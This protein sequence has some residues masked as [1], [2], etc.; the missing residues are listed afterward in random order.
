[1]TLG[2]TRPLAVAGAGRKATELCSH[3]LAL[4]C[5]YWHRE[6][7]TPWLACRSQRQEKSHLEQGCPAQ[8]SLKPPLD[9]QTQ[10]GFGQDERQQMLG[11][12]NSLVLRH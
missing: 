4:L 8:P 6:R 3:L 12:S 1:M 10:G 7:N 2:T 9:P 5:F 11:Y